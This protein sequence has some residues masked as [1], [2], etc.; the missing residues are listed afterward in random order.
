MSRATPAP[1]LASEEEREIARAAAKGLAL[2]LESQ[3]LTAARTAHV[4]IRPG[5]G[6]GPVP[7][8]WTEPCLR[9][10]VVALELLREVLELA[11]QGHGVRLISQH[12]EMTTGEAAEALGVSRPHLVRLLERGDI[13]F[14]RVGAHRRVRYGDVLAYRG[15]TDAAG[16]SGARGLDRPQVDR[17]P[18]DRPGSDTRSRLRS[19]LRSSLG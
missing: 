4:S 6:P 1:P 18:L 15:R 3:P 19:R 12:A 13:P 16:D 14:R 2:L 9:L 10:P 8:R 5:A 17:P 7:G 11:G